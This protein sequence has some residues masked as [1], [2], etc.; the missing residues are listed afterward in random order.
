M[1]LL[2]W[3]QEN[4]SDHIYVLFTGI[5]LAIL[6]KYLLTKS[7]SC[8]KLKL[9]PGPR[10]FPIIGNLH[11]L[12]DSSS[13]HLT[14]HNIGDKYGPIFYLQLGQIPTV[15][16][17]SA[18]LAEEIMKTHDLA[19]C[20]RPRLFSAK[21]LFFN[22][23]EVAFSPYGVYWRGVRKICTLELLSAKRVQSF[24]F[25]REQEVAHLVSRI[26]QSYPGTTN[27]SKIIGLYANDTICR[28]ALGRDY[29]GGGDYDR[30]GFQ[31]MLEDYQELVG[32]FSIGEFFPSME[33]VCTLTGF[34]SKLQQTFRRFDK[35]F[36]E[37]IDEHLKNNSQGE[38]KQKDLVDVLLDI[39]KNGSTDV[40]LTM[41]SVKGIIMDMF[42]AGTDTTFITLDWGMTELLM[43]PRVMQKAQNEVRS[44]LQD[45]RVVEESDLP[46]F[47]YMQAVIKET[48]R[49]HPPA[50]V[51]LPREST[52]DLK[53]DGY[54]IPA[55][56]RIYINARKIG[57]DPIS[58]K[59]PDTFEPERF[60]DSGINYKG[61]NFE[62][63]PFG[64]GRR[65][66]PGITFGEANIELALAQLLHSFDWEL[67][68]G[69]SPKDLDLKE[70]F[71][72]T[73]HRIENLK[74]IA[75]P[76][77]S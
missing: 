77:F 64:A 12:L 10:K 11:H 37:V 4:P 51:L 27:L 2:Q 70:V 9:P 23:A 19:T 50:P 16:I 56:T 69:I 57:R 28:M 1:A 22:C 3:K 76:H 29:S 20:S 31:S 32:G 40:S 14:L 73:M 30:H 13:T 15:V 53:I 55:K 71:G 66:C 6:M 38:K 67:P 46:H 18:R 26:V 74:V 39:Q 5:F 24:S 62:L 54:D 45:R 42:V 58:W 63:I 72:I 33:F 48:L 8:R 59:N 25:I 49:L 35:F 44:I 65:K 52:Q 68:H 17:S 61:Q 41:D 34:K 60:I 75:K 21:Y 7:K 43:N 47:Q 36:D